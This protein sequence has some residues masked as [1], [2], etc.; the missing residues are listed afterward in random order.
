MRA[1]RITVAQEAIDPPHPHLSACTAIGH[2][3][4]VCNVRWSFYEDTE[5]MSQKGTRLVSVGGNDNTIIVWK[6]V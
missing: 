4:H 6:R 2:S 5:D 1:I 3:S